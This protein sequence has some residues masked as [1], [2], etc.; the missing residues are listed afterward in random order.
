[1]W[2][3]TRD[4][5]RITFEIFKHAGKQYGID[6]VNR[7]SAAV[8]YRTMFAMA[9]LLL[10]AV[11]VVGLVLG[12]SDAARVE[13]LDA[14]QRVAGM[15]VADAVDTALGTLADTGSTAGLVGFVLLL[16]TGSSLFL[17]LQNDLN[18]IF[19]VPYEQTTGILETVRKRGLGFLWALALGLI[20]VVAWL[21][22]SIWQFLGDLFP[23]DFEP[24]HRLISILTPLVSVVVLPF[25]FALFTQTLT[26]VRV[27]WKAIWWGSFFTSI[28]FLAASY[29]A[30]LYFR[31]SSGSAARIAGAL[32]VILLLAYILSAVFLFGAEVTMS[33]ARYLETGH[34]G[35]VVP[36]VERTGVVASAEP[37]TPLTAV[38]GFLAGLLVGWRRNR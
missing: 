36:K 24:A 15:T 1:M 3:T 13:I 12:S 21:L 27:R 6:R 14:I 34:L 10:I 29:G 37:A 11:Y 30:S 7:M 25:V 38:L 23:A 28:A 18:D 26:Q 20:L 17:E 35:P 22:N 8:A 31:F 32:F 4:V 9:P 5:A 16:W 2:Q 33:Y 19:G